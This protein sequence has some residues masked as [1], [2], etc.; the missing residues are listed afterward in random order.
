[1]KMKIKVA[2]LTMFL[3]LVTSFPAM[4]ANDPTRLFLLQIPVTVNGVEVPKGVYEFTV[5]SDK[6]NA[7]VTLKKQ[8][9][10]VATAPATLVKTGAAPKHNV[11]LL[12][13]NPDGSR[14]LYEIR[15]AGSEKAIM[16]N[17]SDTVA[18]VSAK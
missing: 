16:L 4:A 3:T 18:Q 5:D 6:S 10:V 7:K 14:A 12:S 2:A 13:V 15:L 17:E 11:V 8:G 9:R 1:M